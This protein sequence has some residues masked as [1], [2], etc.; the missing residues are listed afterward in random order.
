M[1]EYKKKI[2]VYFYTISDIYCCDCFLDRIM[3]LIDSSKEFTKCDE[4]INILENEFS[5]KFVILIF[6]ERIVLFCR[7]LIK[8]TIKIKKQHEKIRLNCCITDF[9]SD[10]DDIIEVCTVC[11]IK[12]IENNKLFKHFKIKEKVGNETY[13]LYL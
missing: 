3:S 5:R 1:I 8:F 4:F 10:G 2:N 9:I 6:G 7:E 11:F 12:I 13:Y